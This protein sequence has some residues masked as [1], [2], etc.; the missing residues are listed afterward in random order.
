MTT[1]ATDILI[2]TI[3]NQIVELLLIITALNN[4]LKPIIDDMEELRQYVREVDKAEKHKI[5]LIVQS[6]RYRLTQLCH[7]YLK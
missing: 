2:K 1:T 5:N 6:Y 3:A 7:L 4:K